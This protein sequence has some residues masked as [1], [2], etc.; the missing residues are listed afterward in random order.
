MLEV[1]TPAGT[2]IV[3]GAMGLVIGW[4]SVLSVRSAVRGPGW[5][6][7][8]LT[9]VGRWLRAAIAIAVLAVVLVRPIWVGLTLVYVVAV[10]W[11]IVRSIGGNLRMVEATGGFVEIPL[12]RS[13]LIV[14]KARV[15]LF[16]AAAAVGLGAALLWQAQPAA[17]VLVA[18]TVGL[19]VTGWKLR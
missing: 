11:W 14:K 12:D 13:R 5:A 1:G 16:A 2:A 10:V 3:V 8:H 9:A 6:L 4:G 17:I 19:A 15:G 18:V 7:N